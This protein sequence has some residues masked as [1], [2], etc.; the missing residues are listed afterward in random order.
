MMPLA[1]IGIGPDIGLF[2]A[3]ILCLS[4]ERIRLQSMPAGRNG[5]GDTWQ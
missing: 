1:I 4:P 5:I 2:E 3:F